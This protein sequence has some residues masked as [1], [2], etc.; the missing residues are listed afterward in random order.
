MIVCTLPLSR[1]CPL[2]SIKKPGLYS[3]R[4][5]FTYK[6]KG[7]LLQGVDFPVD[8]IYSVIISDDKK[9]KSD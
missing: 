1:V 6:G 7:D 9:K 5:S 4:I 8:P 2:I 3:S